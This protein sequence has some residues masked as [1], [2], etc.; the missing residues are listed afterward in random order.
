MWEQACDNKHLNDLIKSGD[1]IIRLEA[2]LSGTLNFIFN[3]ISEEISLSKAIQMAMEQGFAEPDPRIDLSGIDVKR[4]LLI[5]SRESGY[6]FEDSDINII[7]F[8][9]EECF[10]GTVD[11]FWKTVVKY[12]DEFEARRKKIAA[13]NK[14]L[15]YIARLKTGKHQL[16][17]WRL[18][19]FILHTRL[20]A[21]IT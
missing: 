13:Q 18:T 17:S 15:R 3:T 21:A 20:K 11:D 14:R 9:P 4:K 1:K 7:P 12:D 10:R 16:S 6:A 8:L 5:L 19:T 2:V